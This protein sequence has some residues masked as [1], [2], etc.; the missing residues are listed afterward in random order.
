MNPKRFH[1]L[2][3]MGLHH[4]YMFNSLQ[5][6]NG[7]ASGTDIPQF[8]EIAKYAGISHTN[9]SWAPLLF[10]MDNDGWQDLFCFQRHCTFI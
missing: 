2:V 9:W 8:S 7:F 5:L 3:D 6:N 4:Q 10:D 1:N